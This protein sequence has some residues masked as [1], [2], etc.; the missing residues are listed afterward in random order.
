MENMLSYIA[1]LC[2]ANLILGLV[3]IVGIFVVLICL[4]V[5]DRKVGYVK[6]EVELL[7]QHD[8]IEIPQPEPRK[9]KKG[10][11]SEPAEDNTEK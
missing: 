10:K 3:F 11:T 1:R 2:Q 9:K 6:K 5:V 4:A 8:G 7:L